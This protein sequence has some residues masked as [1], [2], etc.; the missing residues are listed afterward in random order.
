MAVTD[1]KSPIVAFKPKHDFPPGPPPVGTNPLAQ[2]RFGLRV[3]GDPLN[4]MLG[5][6]RQYG[7][8]VHL[9]FGAAAH[10]YFLAHPDH[11]HTVLVEKADQFHKSPSY[12][13]EK[14]GLARILGNG[15]VT[16]DGDY[17]RRQR[18]LIQPAFH[19]RR[20]EAYAEEMIRLTRH[21]LQS[22]QDGKTVDV[23]DRMMWLTLA[24]VAKTIL[25]TDITA[26]TEKIAEAVTVFQRL[27]FGVDIFPLW[28]P[29]P[30]H[31]KQRRV[32]KAMNDVVAALITQ[33]RKV[34]EDRGDLLSML[35]NSVDEDGQ[36]MTDKQIRDEIV[37]LFLAGHETTA[38]ALS[39]TWYLLAQHPEVEQ[40]LHDELDSVLHGKPPTLADLKHLP[41]TEQVLQES[42]RLYPPVWNM[43]RQALA[44]VEIGGYIIPKGS[45]VNLNTYAMHHDSRWWENPERFIPERF[46][47]D[48]QINMPKMA[49]LPFSAG[50]RVC[51]GNSFA[52]MEARLILAAV[53]SQYRLRMADGQPSVKMEPL[54][55]LRPQNGLS[56]IVRSRTHVG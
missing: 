32:E 37:T 14:R 49:Y 26:D 16:S 51:I 29:T 24:I 10:V 2:L 20:I 19:A 9:Q 34:A 39:W 47:P 44:D 35:L 42:M 28:M 7:D 15:L 4:V 43:S 8:I 53:A 11:F 36:G 12:K 55:A 1:T 56:M 48:R 23:N 54:I 30:S 5:W 27:A 41:Y 22:W 52:M 31:L 50:P 40:K 38:N 45:E 6:F 17:W 18:K 46:H 33:R 21:L 25:D 13:D 3:T